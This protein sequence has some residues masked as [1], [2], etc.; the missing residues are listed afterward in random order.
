MGMT[1][2]KQVHL[3]QLYEQGGAETAR[4][5]GGTGLGLSICR[6]LSELMGGRISVESSL[7]SGST[8]CFLIRLPSASASE[9]LVLRAQQT[10]EKVRYA[11]PDIHALASKDKPLTILVVDDQPVN[12][13]LL[14][15][16]LVLL[17]LQVEK[18]DSGNAALALWK[19][20]HFDMIITDCHMPDMDG[21]Q[22]TRT[23]RQLE[24]QAARA[25]TPIIAWTAN[26]LADE[27]D[28]SHTA[29]MDDILTK[30][31]ELADLRAMLVKWLEKASPSTPDLVLDFNSLQK[32]THK[33][34]AQIDLLHD[35]NQCN[36]I[37]IAKL[38]A[39][40]ESADNKAAIALAHRIKGAC[41]MVGAVELENVCAAIEQ[42][43]KQGD[44]T[45]ASAIANTT[46]NEAVARLNSSI[47]TFIQAG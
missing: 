29:G 16:Q 26:V 36:L 18:V 22:L 43:L 19:K 25:H 17:G 46:L 5:Y 20:K 14:K 47:Q 23:I 2:E 34:E 33:R 7:G 38:K 8:F 41:R 39:A 11:A 32:I 15:K 30:P 3:F 37:D 10:Q 4:M 27:E 21:Y 1:A 35:L 45:G 13:L 42:A 6:K 28:Q 40:L 24:Q 44:V 9:L 31:T 12:R